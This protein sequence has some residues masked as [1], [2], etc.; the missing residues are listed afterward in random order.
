MQKLKV[1]L[2]VL[3]FC[4]WPLCAS[5]NTSIPSDDVMLEEASEGVLRVE[6]VI[7][8][9]TEMLGEARVDADVPRIDCINGHLV[10]VRGFLNVVQNGAS[11]LR[12]A[13]SRSDVEARDHHYKLLKLAIGKTEAI[14][15]MMLQCSPGMVDFSGQTKRDTSRDCKVKPCL[16]G[17]ELTMPEAENDLRPPADASP[18]L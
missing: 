1:F 6:A 12:D 4:L 5:A 13:I 10:N 9:G 17:S 18:Y 7:A 11:N 15:G 16:E 2:V 14:D 8:H 3:G